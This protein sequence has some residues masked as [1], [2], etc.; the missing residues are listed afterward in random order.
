[1]YLESVSGEAGRILELPEPPSRAALAATDLLEGLRKSWLWTT[2]AQQDV[3]LR[4]RGSILGPF[5]QTLTTA[6]MIGGMGLIYAELFHTELHDYLPM[7]TVGLIFWM[8]IAGMITEGCGT[9]VGVQGIIQQV[10]LPFSLHVYR[11]VYRN[12]LLLAHNFVI[13]PIVLV[14]FPHP[15]NWFRLIE[16]VPGLI[17][18]TI[19]GIWVS[20]LLGMISARFRDVPPIVASIVQVVFFMTPVMWPIGALGPNARWAQFNP[21]FAAVDVLRGPLLG[22]PSARYSWTI[23]AT[24]TVLGCVATFAFFARFRSRIAFWV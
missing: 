19:T 8:F 6:V 17:L 9:F 1:M 2:L 11:L 10:R 5:W 4:Y 12:L 21:L 18:I 22:Q 23:L 7:L 20:V 16:L 15:I 24:I 14:I 13:V 3:K